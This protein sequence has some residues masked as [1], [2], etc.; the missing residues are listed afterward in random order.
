MVELTPGA[1]SA[2]TR[3]WKPSSQQYKE[4]KDFLRK[5]AGIET[6]RSLENSQLGMTGNSSISAILS[7]SKLLEDVFTHKVNPL[8]LLPST[9][10]YNLKQAA[11]SLGNLKSFDDSLIDHSNLDDLRFMHDVSRRL[12]S[13]VFE[14]AM[15]SGLFGLIKSKQKVEVEQEFVRASTVLSKQTK[16]QESVQLELDLPCQVETRKE[17]IV[18]KETRSLRVWLENIEP[19]QWLPNDEL[20]V[21][22]V[23]DT[24]EDREVI[25][26]LVLEDY[27]TCITDFACNGLEAFEKVQVG[28]RNGMRYDLVFMDM[29][30]AEHDGTA[31]ISMI[32]GFERRNKIQ[33]MCNICAVSGD[34]FEETKDDQ[35]NII[36]KAQKPLSLELVKRLLKVVSSQNKDVL[37]P[38]RGDFKQMN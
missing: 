30:M 11:K 12:I 2:H 26:E 16:M 37:S 1:R 6:S 28:Y 8:T 34:E 33:R 31:G 27:P 13:L 32:R 29:N 4:S 20:R 3:G 36:S 35:F 7:E 14:D 25:R 10:A 9:H 17:V 38:V 22:I 21:L 24:Y 23:D 18:Q 19:N 15:S 5:T